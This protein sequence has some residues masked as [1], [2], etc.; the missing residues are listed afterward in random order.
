MIL[1][2][3]GGV[4]KGVVEMVVLRVT[5]GRGL[6]ERVDVRAGETLPKRELEMVGERRGDKVRHW[7][8]VT[9]GDLLEDR[10]MVFR[11]LELLERRVDTER[12]KDLMGDRVGTE[13]FADGVVAGVPT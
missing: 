13:G 7:V 5:L 9:V 2:T 6:R 3:E 11:G 12:V 4:G 1:S 10:E 8:E